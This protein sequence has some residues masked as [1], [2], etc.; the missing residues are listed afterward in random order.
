MAGIEV[1]LPTEWT[2]AQVEEWLKVHAAAVN[3]QTTIKSDIDLFEQGFDRS[4]PSFCNSPTYSGKIAY[5][6]PSSRTVSLVRSMLLLMMTLARSSH[7]SA[8]PWFSHTPHYNHSL[9]ILSISSLEGL[10]VPTQNWKLS[11]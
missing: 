4:V 2:V 11:V 3:S 8:Q 9:T 7:S 6:P 5:Q 10:V 1:P